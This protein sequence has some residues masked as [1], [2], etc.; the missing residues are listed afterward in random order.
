M[1]GLSK[2]CVGL[3]LV[4]SSRACLRDKCLSA[5]VVPRGRVFPF[6][7]RLTSDVLADDGAAAMTAVSSATLAF[8]NAGIPLS[9]PVA[10]AHQILSSMFGVSFGKR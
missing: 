6:A 1:Q 3:Y 7:I 8:A 9:T 5:G 2:A 4:N 10:G